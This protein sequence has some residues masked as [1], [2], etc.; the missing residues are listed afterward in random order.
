MI[1]KSLKRCPTSKKYTLKE[2]SKQL[3]EQT[4]QQFFFLGGG[5]HDVECLIGKSNLVFV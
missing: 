5:F 3:P 1:V 2:L 4:G